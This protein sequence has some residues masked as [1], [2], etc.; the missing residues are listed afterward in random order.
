[1][2]T[3]ICDFITQYAKSDALRLHM[4]GHKGKNIVGA[5]C[6]DITEI[7]GADN[8]YDANSIIKESEDNAS[9]IFGAKTFYSTEGSSQCIRAMLYLACLYAKKANKK[10]IIAAFRNVHKTFISAAALLDFDIMWIYPENQKSYLS[11]KIDADTLEKYLLSAKEIPLAVY[12]TSPDYIGNIIDINAISKVCHK[13]G[14]LLLVDNAHGAYLKFLDKS[15]HPIDLGADICCASAHKTLPALTG[16]A[17]LHISHNAP[18]IFKNQAKDALSMFGS[19]SP[20]YLILQSLD[21]LNAYLND[22]YKKNLSDFT[23]K[24]QKLKQDLV[25]HGYHLCGDEILKI[26]IDAKKYGYNGKKFAKILLKKNIVCEFYDNDFVVMMITLQTGIDGLNKIKKALISI[27]K[28]DE[29]FEKPPMPGICEFTMSIRQA[30]F[31]QNEVIPVEKSLGRILAMPCVC[32]P[33]AVPIIVCG[34]RIDE[35]AIK[36]FSYY[37]IKNCTVVK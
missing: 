29:I 8:L 7:D 37:G 22:G 20:S 30:A 17:Y 2:K 34:E 16:S 9:A 27:P 10:P 18:D 6:Y 31:S 24:V 11:C 23:Y 5:E 33:P 12:L 25:S 4:P 3:P 35:N 28:A 21:A 19:T 13:Y 15:C 36:C 1:M 26:T 14:V 32:C